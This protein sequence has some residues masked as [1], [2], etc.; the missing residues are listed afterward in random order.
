MS[1]KRSFRPRAVDLLT[2]IECE[3]A[4]QILFA[5]KVPWTERDSVG[6]KP[7]FTVGAA[8]YLDA[9]SFASYYYGKARTTNASLRRYFSWL[10][11][12]LLDALR[13]ELEAPVELENGMALPGFHVFLGGSAYESKTS[14]VHADLQYRLVEFRDRQIDESKTL[15]FTLLVR[16]PASGAGLILWNA[17]FEPEDELISGRRSARLE[18]VNATRHEYAVGRLFLHSGMQYHAIAPIDSPQDSDERITLQ[19]HAVFA[20]GRWFVYW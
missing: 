3:R 6:G 15:S 4:R 8:S 20:D 16:A 5:G 9:L 18:K 13:V 7:F 11:S 10:Y 19:G 17:E 1:R 12:K 14:S 2:P